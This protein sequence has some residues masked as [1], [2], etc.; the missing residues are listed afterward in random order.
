MLEMLNK[1]VSQFGEVET[2]EYRFDGGCEEFYAWLQRAC[3][4]YEADDYRL[5]LEKSTK[6]L[7]LGKSDLV[8]I[9]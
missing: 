6:E 7:L 2:I 5:E 9:S 8:L 3:T 4:T 1:T